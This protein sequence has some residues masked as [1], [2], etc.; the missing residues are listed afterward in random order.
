M[1][2]FTYISKKYSVGP[3]LRV[4]FPHHMRILLNLLQVENQKYD[5]VGKYSYSYIYFVLYLSEK[6]SF[7]TTITETNNLPKNL[8]VKRV[9][10]N[11]VD[12]GVQFSHEH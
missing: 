12:E 1:F 8:S 10:S 9:Q 4:F 2:A 6:N 7:V 3:K 11:F 5:H